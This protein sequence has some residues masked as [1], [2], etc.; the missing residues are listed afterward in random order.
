MIVSAWIT[1]AHEQKFGIHN[2]RNRY[3]KQNE[4]KKFGSGSAPLKKQKNCHP[5][6]EVVN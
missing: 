3:E 1:K 5:S 6:I 2:E 4:P